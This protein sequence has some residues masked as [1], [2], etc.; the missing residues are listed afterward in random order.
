MITP[1]LVITYRSVT[2]VVTALILLSIGLGFAGYGPLVVLHRIAQP[3]S[4][5]LHLDRISG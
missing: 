5:E 4:H 3:V 2:A 1:P